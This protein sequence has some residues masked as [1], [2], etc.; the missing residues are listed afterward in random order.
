[1]WESVTLDQLR[2][3]LTVAEEGSFSAAGRRLGRVPSAVGYGISNLE[4]SLG[5]T[6]FDR[7]AQRIALTEEGRAL[8]PDAE[9]VFERVAQL[10]LRADRLG[11]K[12]ETHLSVALEAMLPSAFVV[13]LC[14]MFKAHYPGVSLHLRTEGL[15][16]VAAVVMDE[17]CVLGVSGGYDLG[18]GLRS[19]L[20]AEL[21]LVVVAAKSHPLT[22]HP[23]PIPRHLLRQEPQILIAH[24]RYG[25]GRA[26]GVL[27]DNVLMVAG[28]EIKLDLIAAGFGWGVVPLVTVKEALERGD[29]VG[30]DLEERGGVLSRLPIFG[31]VRRDAPLGPAAQWL[32]DAL[33]GLG[34]R[35][36]ALETASG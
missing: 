3:F 33:R 5:L 10:H 15:G 34:D 19:Q 14:A 9:A 31:I 13:A 28:G 1:M 8:L 23:G 17:T 6:L 12:L 11:S 22:R 2:L 36:D 26:Q 27:S 18:P 7:S 35:S 29:L 25:S 16:G 4:E 32:Y 20:L 24:S 21:P 30:L